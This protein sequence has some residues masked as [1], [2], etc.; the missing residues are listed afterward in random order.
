[1]GINIVYLRRVMLTKSKKKIKKNTYYNY[2]V[3]F[4]KIKRILKIRV[5]ANLSV[6]IKS[7]KISVN[8]RVQIC[9]FLNLLK[10]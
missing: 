7:E 10:N 8:K 2:S 9:M 6:I 3:A 1:M 4:V 5:I